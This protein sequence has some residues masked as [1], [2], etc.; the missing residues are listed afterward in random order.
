[1]APGRNRSFLILGLLILILLIVVLTFYF[2][3]VSGN[4]KYCG[5]GTEHG[6]C[7]T[8]NVGY[9]CK[10]GEL[11]ERADLCGCSREFKP[12]G[13]DCFSSLNYDKKFVRMNYTLYGSRSFFEILVYGGVL[14]YLDNTTIT[15][16][17]FESENPNRENFHRLNIE[18]SVQE[19][20]LKDLVVEVQN[21]RVDEIERFRAAVSLVQN[22]PYGFSEKEDL[23]FGEFNLTHSR[24]PYEVIYD[25]QGVCGERSDLL[26]FL[27]RELGYGSAIFYFPEAN[28]EFVG[29]KCPSEVS[30]RNTGYCSIETT[31]PSIISFDVSEAVDGSVLGENFEIYEMYSGKSLPLEMKEYADADAYENLMEVIEIHGALTTKEKIQLEKLEWEYGL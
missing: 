27:L 6:I 9:I 18:D 15:E 14:D 24:Y 16:D 12:I 22:I 21:S 29:I 20:F 28:H 1:M 31:S 30:F 26:V 8:E 17:F 7:S 11:I 2:F 13:A 3:P 25:N 5:D 4:L 23:I 19:D 10:R